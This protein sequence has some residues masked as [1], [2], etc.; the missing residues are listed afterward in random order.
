MNTNGKGDKRRPENREAI[1]DN[2][3][4]I[5][6]KSRQQSPAKPQRIQRR[7]VKG[8]NLQETSKAVNGLECVSCCRPGRWGN[9]FKVKCETIPDRT[10]AQAVELFR[11]RLELGIKHQAA[12]GSVVHPGYNFLWMADHLEDLR[13]K[14]LACFCPVGQPCHADVLLEFAN[15]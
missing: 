3:E 6:W 14:N 11:H 2:W 15:R 4:R 8:F 1:E 10:P 13:G 9:P 5:N 7:R 12:P